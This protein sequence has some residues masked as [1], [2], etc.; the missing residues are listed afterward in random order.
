[1]SSPRVQALAK[2]FPPDRAA[3]ISSDLKAARDLPKHKRGIRA[4]YPI[5]ILARR[6]LVWSPTPGHSESDGPDFGFWHC[7]A[8]NNAA[9]KWAGKKRAQDAVGFGNSD[10]H[11]TDPKIHDRKVLRLLYYCPEHL[12]DVMRCLISRFCP[13][14][15]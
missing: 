11:W 6:G 15:L 14:P 5:G 10:K 2:F 8:C 4:L 1:M 12:K 13:G 3:L 9:C 7:V